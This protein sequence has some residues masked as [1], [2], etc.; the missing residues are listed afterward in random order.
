MW[1][2]IGHF[3]PVLVHLPIGI[4][5]LVLLFEA[6]SRLEP[7]RSLSPAVPIVLLMGCLSAIFSCFTGWLMAGSGDYEQALADKHQWF[8]IGVALLSVLA[9]WMKMKRY[10]SVY[11]MVS[12]AILPGILITAHWGIS[13]SHGTNYLQRAAMAT[14]TES[15]TF[16]ADI[17]DVEVA[18]ISEATLTKIRETGIVVLPVGL[19]QPFLSLNFVSVTE[20]TPDMLRVLEPIRENVVWIKM[21]GLKLDDQTLKHLSGYEN[22]TRLSLDHTNVTDASLPFLEHCKRLAYLNLVGTG[23]SDQG[24]ST[25]SSIPALRH[26]FLHQTRVSAAAVEELRLKVPQI[27]IDT[28]HY[29]LPLLPTDT[30]FLK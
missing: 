20:I 23:V 8:G 12:A 30:T 14:T 29:L 10:F 21:T 22:L 5:L 27:L 9:F 6:M 13:L 7:Y 17:P 15:A 2:I 4:L 18:A 24:V 1:E 11:R 16:A 28:G 25:L 19:D 26:L 3:H